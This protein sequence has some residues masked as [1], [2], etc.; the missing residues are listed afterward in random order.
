MENK[1]QGRTGSGHG[2]KSCRYVD[3]TPRRYPREGR[4][5][6]LEN[7]GQAQRLFRAAAEAQSFLES[8][9]PL[10]ARMTEADASEATIQLMYKSYYAEMG[11]SGT[12]P[13]I[14]R[15]RA[16]RPPIPATSPRSAGRPQG[17]SPPHPAR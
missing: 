2:D 3:R 9:R 11:G 1:G 14:P 5:C 16:S 8:Y 17:R 12:P 10:L 4:F 7:V 13:E 6:N 15:A